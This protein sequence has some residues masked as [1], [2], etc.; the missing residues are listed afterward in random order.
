MQS[1]K[2]IGHENEA[3]VVEIFQLTQGLNV[4]SDTRR[5]WYHG[6]NEDSVLYDVNKGFFGLADGVGGGQLGHVAS[7]ALLK[8]LCQQH[9]SLPNPKQIVS[10]LKASDRHIAGVLANHGARGASTVVLAW[11]NDEAEGYIS[12]VGDARIYLFDIKE[13]NLDNQGKVTLQQLTIDQTYEN[14]SLE[15]PDNRQPDDPIRMVGVGAVGSPPVLKVKLEHNQG[16]F[17]CSDGIHKFLNTEQMEEIFKNHFLENLPTSP[18]ELIA[19]TLVQEAINYDSHDDCSALVVLNYQACQHDNLAITSNADNVEN[20][21]KIDT[22]NDT[23]NSD[24]P[25]LKSMTCIRSQALD[26]NTKKINVKGGISNIKDT[27]NKAKNLNVHTDKNDDIKI[28][29]KKQYYSKFFNETNRVII[30]LL[31]LFYLIIY[32]LKIYGLL[33]DK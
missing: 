30:L 31:V 28:N 8:F 7:D 25:N 2:H 17:F 32:A 24:K 4:F 19:N 33:C 22:A 16:L 26:E 23:K 9:E 11:L 29:D 27:K 21:G 10:D 14:L 3:S 1:T 6:T 5:G 15:V 13:A 12:N 20:L 18:L